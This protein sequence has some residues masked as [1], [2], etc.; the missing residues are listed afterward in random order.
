MKRTDKMGWRLILMLSCVVLVWTS[1]WPLMPLAV[2]EVSVWTFR[3]ISTFG[4]GLML[5]SYAR[6]RGQ[7][8][9]FLKEDWAMV[10]LAAIGYPF[11]FSTASVWSAI[12]IPSGQAAILGFTMPFWI[13]LLSWFF[14][15]RKFN[16]IILIA[17]CFAIISVCLLVVD[18]FET[19][20]RE[21]LGV[22][23]GLIAAIGWAANSMIIE[24]RP[25]RLSPLVLAGWQLIICSVPISCLAF[26]FGEGNW[27]VPTWRSIF[28]IG[29][30]TIMPMGLGNAVWFSIIS[31]VPAHIAG[32]SMIFV[33]IL[34]MLSGTIA[35]GEPLGF[36]Q[37]M[38][39]GCC[40]I[41]LFLVLVRGR[42]HIR[43][44]RVDRG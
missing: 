35:Y 29:W 1:N 31:Y 43:D 41:A 28:V 16:I 33:P 20:R 5:L 17:L 36:N 24:R 37:I 9:K 42:D 4:A 34:A 2:Q 12:M 15:G 22:V 39:M 32:I 38:S 11:V 19:Y 23:L 26:I 27:F 13:I 18:N 21:P 6:M 7:S 44:H 14:F 30:Q 25:P 10:C 3:A 8:I 40:F